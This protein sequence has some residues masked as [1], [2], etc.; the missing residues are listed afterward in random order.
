MLTI[1]LDDP[2]SLPAVVDA[3]CAQIA[4]ADERGSESVARTLRS[5]AQQLQAAIDAEGAPVRAYLQEAYPGDSP[6]FPLGPAFGAPR[7]EPEACKHPPQYQI[8][9]QA[10]A[11]ETP[12]GM[13][14]CV[15]CMA[16]GTVLRGAAEEIPE[17]VEAPAPKR[18]R[19]RKQKANPE[20]VAARSEE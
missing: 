18:K 12:D 16:C 6:L 2:A 14:T 8:A 5:I 7:A 13:M 11:P 15:R 1:T 17:R 3:L 4:L 19:T 10:Y 9:W 20:A